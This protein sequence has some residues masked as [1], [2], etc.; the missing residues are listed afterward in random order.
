MEI[1]PNVHHIPG[2]IANPFLIVEP[3]GLTLIDCGLAGSEKKILKYI[4][5]LGRAPRDLKR[6]LITHADGDHVGALAALQAATGARVY[7]SAFEAECIAQGKQPRPLKP[8]GWQKILFALIL[9][10]TARLFTAK[11]ARVDEILRDGQTLPVLGEL[12][13][14][15]TIG[16]TPGHFS[17]FAP[18]PGI[19]FVGDSLIAQGDVLRGSA[20]MNT[21][22]Q[23][24]ANAAV[25]A[26]AARAPQMVCSGHGAVVKD[27]AGKFPRV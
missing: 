1:A 6:I 4:A 16:H 11:P 2:I 12:R 27:A 5:D 13:A 19:L 8:H 7:A 17:F 10:V 20:G 3:D 18:T 14:L 22:D 15:A 26:Q 23:E 21:W 24:K 25:R 9:P